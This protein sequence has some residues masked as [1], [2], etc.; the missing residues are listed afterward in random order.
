MINPENLSPRL[1]E[2]VEHLLPDEH[3][4]RQKAISHIVAALIEQHTCRQSDLARAFDN[5]E[6]AVKRISR[7]IHN[8]RLKDRRAADAVLQQSLEQLPPHGH[9]RLAIDWT[10]EAEGSPEVL[11]FSGGE[12]TLHPQI[13][14]FIALAKAKGINY[15]MLNTNGIRIA[16]DDQFL[17]GIAHVKPH[18]YLQFDG[19]DASTN[20]ALRGRPDLIET[21]LRALDRLAAADVRIVLV[22]VIERGINEHEIGRIVE[23]GVKHPAVF[24]IMFHS[25][26]HTA[27][28]IPFDPIQRITI[29]DVLK[30]LETQ[31]NG[32][33][34]LSDFVPVPCCMPTC[35][36]VTYTL[37]D[38][39]MVTPLPRVLEVDHYLDYLKNRPCQA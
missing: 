30:S 16:R 5:F 27:R 29:P 36:F 19:F 1:H 12:P 39:D 14:D 4:H 17:E 13:L 32:L 10:I 7:L 31:T 11:Q 37:L 28:H 6:A 33:F 23:F 9:I 24:G 2:F 18:I 22:A 34:R 38:G 26:F 25:A 20:A 8:A 3:G 21:K 35:H 15:V